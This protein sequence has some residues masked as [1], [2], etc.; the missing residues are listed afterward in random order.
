MP[1]LKKTSLR[2]IPTELPDVVVV[3]P[4]VFSDARGLFL[5]TYNAETYEQAGLPAMMVQDNLSWS[6]AGV[7]RGLHYQHPCPQGKL[8]QV[9][10]GEVFDVAVDIRAGSPTFGRWS[11][12]TLSS[13]NRRQVYIPEG[14]AHGFCV[15][16]DHAL[17]SYK[18]TEVYRPSCDAGIAWNDP[19]IGIKWPVKTPVLSAKDQASP[20][21][22]D[23]PLENLPLYS[24]EEGVQDAESHEPDLL[25]MPGFRVV[26]PK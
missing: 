25:S 24:A 14:F 11:G 1:E 15:T 8:V 6:R 5:E 20:R 18:C 19:Q 9:L 17:V 3:E 13:T 2:V 22:A 12:V 26:R 21:L 23:V 4:T 10:D 7:L 16:S